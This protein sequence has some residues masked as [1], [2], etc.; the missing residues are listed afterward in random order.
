MCTGGEV[1]K[2]T[3]CAIEKEPRSARKTAHDDDEDARG[4][5]GKKCRETLCYMRNERVYKVIEAFV[6][7][8]GSVLRIKRPPRGGSGIPVDT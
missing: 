7:L 8:R 1:T 3:K 5:Y 6:T 2:I 4:T